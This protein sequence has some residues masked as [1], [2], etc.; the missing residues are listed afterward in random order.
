M[1]PRVGTD[2][3]QRDAMIGLY[4]EI[5][6]LKELF[7]RAILK[8]VGESDISLS[9][10]GAGGIKFDF[11]NV[12]GK[13]FSSH[14]VKIVGSNRDISE[15]LKDDDFGG[16]KFIIRQ[17]DKNANFEW[18][19]PKK[20][21]LAVKKFYPGYV[22]IQKEKNDK[23]FRV[24]IEKFKEEFNNF[25]T[26]Y[27]LSLNKDYIDIFNIGYFNND[28]FD[29]FRIFGSSE[30]V[31]WVYICS[32]PVLFRKKQ[33]DDSY[34]VKLTGKNPG[35][36]LNLKGVGDKTPLN[37]LNEIEVLDDFFRK[38]F[39]SNSYKKELNVI[40]LKLEYERNSRYPKRDRKSSEYNLVGRLSSF[41]MAYK[42]FSLI[43][44]GNNCAE[45]PEK[46]PSGVVGGQV[47]TFRM[48]MPPSILA[49][50]SF[51]TIGR[52]D[53]LY[54]IEYWWWVEPKDVGNAQYIIGLLSFKENRMFR[55]KITS[56]SS[57]SIDQI[58]DDR[59]FRF[60][61]FVFF[62]NDKRKFT[63]WYASRLTRDL[64]MEPNERSKNPKRI[65][66][67][68]FSLFCAVDAKAALV[69]FGS[70]GRK[71]VKGPPGRSPY[72]G[73]Q[74][75][76]GKHKPDGVIPGQSQ[77]ARA[78]NLGKIVRDAN[79]EAV[80]F[81]RP[82]SN[83]ATDL[84]SAA[85]KAGPPPDVFL[86][87]LKDTCDSPTSSCIPSFEFP[88]Q[89]WCHLL[90]HGEGGPDAQGNLSAGSAHS[91]T[92][93]CAIEDAIRKSGAKAS[94]RLKI[95]AYTLPLAPMKR[96]NLGRLDYGD[97]EF[98]SEITESPW[99]RHKAPPAGGDRMKIEVEGSAL[100]NHNQ[101]NS[102]LVM[103][104]ELRK[105]LLAGEEVKG[106]PKPD[107]VVEKIIEE[108]A[109]ISSL[110][111]S[112]NIG[113]AP[114]NKEILAS[115]RKKIRNNVHISIKNLYLD[116]SSNKIELNFY[117]GLRRLYEAID[118]A[119]FSEIPVSI[120]HRYKIYLDNEFKKY[121]KRLVIDYLV[122][123]QRE[124]FDINNFKL[125]YNMILTRITDELPVLAIDPQITDEL[126]DLEIVPKITEELH[127]P[128]IVPGILPPL[129]PEMALESLKNLKSQL[130]AQSEGNPGSSSNNKMIVEPVPGLAMERRPYALLSSVIDQIL[131]TTHRSVPS[132]LI[133]M[134]KVPN[135]RRYRKKPS[136]KK[137]TNLKKRHNPGDAD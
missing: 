68:A 125:L 41:A 7:G 88:P 28:E 73:E 84:A 44:V 8:A 64:E 122:D 14:N 46:I 127:A 27:F 118:K 60:R 49:N 74:K 83:S 126:P 76:E 75:K 26:K 5:G 47:E 30:G 52:A 129:P 1:L 51:S 53:P 114:Q 104:G 57:G 82:M 137:G 24:I 35:K 80:D 55:P 69:D 77:G 67:Q 62:P 59:K 17:S 87:Y 11:D 100:P 38:D 65:P 85:Y 25:Y 18:P 90:A 22:L 23:K 29:I 71:K 66:R 34:T 123:S 50:S 21:Y 79:E 70:L 2:K 48:Y 61:P 99:F 96:R 19:R 102:G 10:H 103:R 15:D 4:Y 43:E 39:S 32:F 56:T 81:L 12:I 105:W 133:Q 63:I 16:L 36:V 106:L 108:I 89:E 135:A 3:R 115:I 113:S 134:S 131:V 6:K 37:F 107:E 117:L 33:S 20:E 93:E 92:E 110:S 86:Q 58:I 45:F 101:E 109:N 31:N 121:N 13:Y 54:D 9:S 136:G 124:I 116:K 111:I 72:I 120:F 95:T 94:L 91:N 119:I 112:K 78:S 98:L 130:H 42:T 132:P 40:E 128:K 97:S